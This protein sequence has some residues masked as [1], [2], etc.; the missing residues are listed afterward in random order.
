MEISDKQIL[1]V[2]PSPTDW[3]Q[4][5]A[6]L[7]KDNGHEPDLKPELTAEEPPKF[8]WRYDN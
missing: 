1:K 7:W 2:N 5:L 3:N 6:K 4:Y 8:G